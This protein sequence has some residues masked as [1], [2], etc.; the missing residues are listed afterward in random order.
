M[1]AYVPR[2]YTKAL[3]LGGVLCA[4]LVTVVQAEE[5]P[6]SQ[7]CKA[8]LDAFNQAEQ[9]LAASAASQPDRERQRM[10]SERLY[11][12]RK[13]VADACLGGLTTSPLPS[14]RTWVV[15]P[16][17]PQPGVTAPRVL[18]PTP[19]PVAVTVPR[20]NVP[21]LVTHCNA[22]TCLTSDGATL[23]RAGP[24]L[25]GPR[26]LCTVQGNVLRCP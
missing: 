21:T 4:L 15:P 10:V 25:S 13:R 11:P 1:N 19:P 7:G 6:Q 5:L 3:S 16:S 18:V 20:P 8:A 22:A 26:G 2:S 12:L 23:N 14:Q 9:G 17:P 24:N